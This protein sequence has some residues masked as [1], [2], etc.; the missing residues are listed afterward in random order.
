MSPS[1]RDDY[2]MRMIAEMVQALM[3]VAGLKREGK[4]DEALDALRDAYGELLGP[5]AELAP[6]LDPATAAQVVGNAERIRAWAQLLGEE[7][8]VRRLRGEDSAADALRVRALELALEAHLRRAGEPA[9][10]HELVAALAAEVPEERLAG[11]YRP[12]LR[13]LLARGAP[14]PVEP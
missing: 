3:R 2:L 12:V 4:L 1:A 7:A 11:A 8:E 13:D 5:A 9:R 14:R 10:T 6:R